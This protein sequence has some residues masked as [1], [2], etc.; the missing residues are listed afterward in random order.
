MFGGLLAGFSADKLGRKPTVILNAV[1]YL[2]GWMMI[3]VSWYVTNVPAFN[4]LI[5]SGRFISGCGFGWA[6][7]AG[8][9]RK[10]LYMDLVVLF[11]LLLYSLGVYWR[12]LSTSSE[13]LL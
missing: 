2:V 12:N 1:P 4:V 13:G 9:V 7:L 10:F 5:M 11:S 8:P 3:G 6:V